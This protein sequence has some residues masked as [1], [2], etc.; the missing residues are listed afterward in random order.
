[1]LLREGEC[2]EAVAQQP[3]VGSRVDRTDGLA[4]EVRDEARHQDGRVQLHWARLDR[5]LARGLEI[6]PPHLREAHGR[7]CGNTQRCEWPTRWSEGSIRAPGLPLSRR[8]LRTSYQAVKVA[9]VQSRI[10]GVGGPLLLMR[11]CLAMT[12]AP[13][14]H[15]NARPRAEGTAAVMPAMTKYRAT[16]SRE[17]L[18]T[19]YGTVP[20]L[21][22]GNVSL[23]TI[24]GCVMKVNAL[25]KQYPTKMRLP[26]SSGA[27]RSE[28]GDD[29]GW[30]EPVI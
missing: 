16:T 11:T 4:G 25:K 20:A 26:H 3:P 12:A 27:T 23:R 10:I 5:L 24:R 9:T 17:K 1:M 6:R 28:N 13:T 30:D 19:S 8:L 2:E 21:I 7:T 22:S 14:W 18:P 15:A 29:G